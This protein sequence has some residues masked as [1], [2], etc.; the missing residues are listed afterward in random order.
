MVLL[1][2]RVYLMQRTL[3]MATG[4]GLKYQGTAKVSLDQIQFDPPLPRNLDPKNLERLEQVFREDCCR[5]YNVENYVPAVVSQQ[6][7]TSALEL[8]GV[9]QESLMTDSPD[10]SPLIRFPPE[11]CGASTDA[12]AFRLAPNSCLPWTV[13]G[14]WICTWTI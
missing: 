10:Q 3:Q 6:D 4:L 14:W 8:A 9:P 13:G 11:N 12:I 5:R 1:K 7:L 2:L